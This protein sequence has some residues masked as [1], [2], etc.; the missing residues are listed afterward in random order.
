[1]PRAGEPCARVESHKGEC[2]TAAALGAKSEHVKRRQREKRE[3]VDAY[4]LER[5]CENCGYREDARALDLDHR[6]R[7]SKVGNV[8]RLVSSASRDRL[9]AELSKCR[10]LCSNCHR[11]KTFDNA[12]HLDTKRGAGLAHSS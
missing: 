8:A 4:K 7:V 10:V 9:L 3:A 6:D 12:E 11:I 5:G 2:G 1:M